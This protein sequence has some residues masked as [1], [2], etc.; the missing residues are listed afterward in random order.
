MCTVQAEIFEVMWRD[1]AAAEA[2]RL[3]K[4]ADAD[5][6]EA[7]AMEATAAALGS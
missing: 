7:E 3:A 2:V 6:L 5:R 4:E 1:D